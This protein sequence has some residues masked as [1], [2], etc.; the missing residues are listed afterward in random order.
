MT[1]GNLYT[2]SPTHTGTPLVLCTQPKIFSSKPKSVEVEVRVEGDARSCVDNTDLTCDKG[3]GKTRGY[4]LK[5][6]T[7][8][9][10]GEDNHGERRIS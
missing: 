10:R 7:I 2:D 3:Q 4:E 6:V 5:W 8:N 1:R 9:E